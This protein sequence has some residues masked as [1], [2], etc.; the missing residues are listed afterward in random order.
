[1]ICVQT[2]HCTHYLFQHWMKTMNISLGIIA[3]HFFVVGGTTSPNQSA[4]TAQAT[5][6]PTAS[7]VLVNEDTI[8]FDAY[9]IGGNN[10][11]KLRDIAKI[12]S[13]TSKQFE[14][15]WDNEKQAINLLSGKAYSVVGG[16]LAKGDN[17]SKT[18]TV[19]TSKVFLDG[20]EI[21]LTSY[22]IGG[23]NYFKLRD[24]GK[25]FDFGVGWDGAANTVAIDMNKIYVKE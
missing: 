2:V 20:K 14:V 3:S 9:E 7:K 25:T 17:S 16:E 21:S 23:N 1:M 4:N 18:A 6:K 8:S 13:G 24:L 19:N 11:F 5:A 15:T 10:F 22:T 12:L